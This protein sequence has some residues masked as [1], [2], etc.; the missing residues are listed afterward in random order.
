MSPSGVL[1]VC[2][3]PS[4]LQRIKKKKNTLC[5]VDC[6]VPRVCGNIIY[7]GYGLGPNCYIFSG[8]ITKLTLYCIMGKH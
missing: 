4:N 7:C 5:N 8:V 3:T 6:F 1:Q 2:D